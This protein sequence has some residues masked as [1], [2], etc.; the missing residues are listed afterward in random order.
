[1]PKLPLIDAVENLILGSNLA[2]DFTEKR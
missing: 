1:L 2:D